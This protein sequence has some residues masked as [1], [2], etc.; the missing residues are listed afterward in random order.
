MI[1]VPLQVYVYK[2]HGMYYLNAYKLILMNTI[3][4]QMEFNSVSVDLKEMQ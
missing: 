1:Q 2:K 4:D 3:M